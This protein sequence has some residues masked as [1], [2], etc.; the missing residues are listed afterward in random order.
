MD[1]KEFLRTCAGGLCACATACVAAPAAIAETTPAED[2][3][4]PFVKE[5]YAKLLN[6]LL[7]KMGEE[8]LTAAL[9][10]VGGYCASTFGD[11]L[12][13]YRGDVE[14]FAEFI[15]NDGSGDLPIYDRERN[16]IVATS[17]ERTDCICPLI[18]IAAK[19]PK[20]VCNCSMGWHQY[21]WETLLQKK[22]RVELKE[23]VLRGGKRCTL[24]V[25]I[26]NEPV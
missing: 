7:D 20:V 16:V 3:R 21:A 26:L 18:G 1:R 24:E 2:W 13:K 6:V 25:H 19:T 22:V 15:K 14:G 17:K 5:R 10:D 11:A 23:S 9:H 8:N 12:K 4:V